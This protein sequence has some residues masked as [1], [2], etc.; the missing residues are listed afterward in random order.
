MSMKNDQGLKALYDY[1]LKN[2]LV[3][4]LK[5]D[6]LETRDLRSSYSNEKILHEFQGA[7]Q[8]KASM[9]AFYHQQTPAAH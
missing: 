3:Y 7:I 9:D 6:P 2:F 4:D 5:R 8:L 1:Q